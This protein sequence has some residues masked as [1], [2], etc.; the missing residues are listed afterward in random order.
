MGIR[1]DLNLDK[2]RPMF[3]VIIYKTYKEV[4]NTHTWQAYIKIQT[5][6]KFTC[7]SKNEINRD[8]R[9]QKS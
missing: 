7:E 3:H 5:F 1:K 8:A 9:A 2:S 6:T 4:I